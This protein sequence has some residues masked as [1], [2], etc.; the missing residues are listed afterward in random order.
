[1]C[2]CLFFLAT[3][4]FFLLFL[5]HLAPRKHLHLHLALKPG[6]DILIP[7]DSISG[8]VEVQV[9]VGVVSLLLAFVAVGGEF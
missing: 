1:M 6:Q 8:G 3:S 2:L 9:G 4:F 5:S 7:V